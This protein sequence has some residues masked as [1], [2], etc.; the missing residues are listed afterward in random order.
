[1]WLYHLREASQSREEKGTLD[2]KKPYFNN[3]YIQLSNTF[4]FWESVSKDDSIL[5]FS[6]GACVHQLT[7]VPT[8]S[9]YHICV[10]FLQITIL[11]TTDSSKDAVVHAS[12]NIFSS[13]NKAEKHKNSCFVK[14][15][16]AQPCP[17]LE[18]PWTAACQAPLY[19]GFSRQEYWSG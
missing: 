19:M 18:T 3:Q 1:M 4:V 14:V 16:V 13:R 10:L 6:Y 17:T 8:T 9:H 2:P 7:T 5:A 12:N 11:S 15:K